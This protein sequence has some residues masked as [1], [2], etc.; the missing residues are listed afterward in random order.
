M[1]HYRRLTASDL[2]ALP[3]VSLYEQMAAIGG[4]HV[5]TSGGTY[6]AHVLGEDHEGLPG[7][8]VCAELSDMPSSTRR[9]V[10]E[11][12]WQETEDAPVQRTKRA[13]VPEGAL[14]VADYLN[15]HEWA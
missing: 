9:H 8:F 13:D 6:I 11:A 1:H 3:G 15:P 7:T 2:E 14:V 10:Q 12:L 4:V 5:G